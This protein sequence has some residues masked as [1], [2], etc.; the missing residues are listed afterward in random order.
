MAVEVSAL[1]DRE[2]HVMD[3][4]LDMA[5]R[6]Q[7][8]RMSADDA[9]NSATHDHLLACD[10]P[11]DLPLL[12]NENLSR[13]NITLNVAIDLQRTPANDPEPLTNDLEVIPNYGLLAARR[14]G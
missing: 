1:F 10:H 12:A 2:G 6:L 9:Q 11:R 7:G 8:N 13:L 3:I 14:R 4:G 5:G